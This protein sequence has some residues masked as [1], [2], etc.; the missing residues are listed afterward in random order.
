MIFNGKFKGKDGRKKNV[1]YKIPFRDCKLSYIGETLQWYDIGSDF[2]LPDD[3]PGKKF[4]IVSKNKLMVAPNR[5]D[6]P[7]EVTRQKFKCVHVRMHVAFNC[8]LG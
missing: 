1:I 7:S 2:I 4:K 6:D 3:L 8:N 5:Q